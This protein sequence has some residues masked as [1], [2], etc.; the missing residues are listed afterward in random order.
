MVSGFP[1]YKVPI[2]FVLFIFTSKLWSCYFQICF[3][4][5]FIPRCFTKFAWYSFEPLKFSFNGT[6]VCFLADLSK[7]SSFLV[8]FKL[9]FFYIYASRKIWIII[10]FVDLRFKRFTLSRKWWT[11]QYLIAQWRALIQIKNNSRP[12]VRPWRTSKQICL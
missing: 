3:S 5:F 2:A 12:K 1:V 7:T 9:F 6:P 4:S 8:I 10:Y 11:Y